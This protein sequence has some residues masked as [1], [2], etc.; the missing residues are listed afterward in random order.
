MNFG[1]IKRMLAWY[2]AFV[3]VFLLQKPLFLAVHTPAGLAVGV[4]DYLAVAWHGLAMDLCMAAYLSVVPALLLIWQVWARGRGPVVAQVVYAALVSVALAAVAVLDLAL[5]GYWGFRLDTTPLFY[6]S[7]SPSS[8]LASVSGWT[9]A[10]GTLGWLLTAT[11]IFLVLRQIAKSGEPCERSAEGGKRRVRTTAVLVV[12]TVALFVPMRGGVTVSTMNLSRAYFSAVPFLNHAAINPAFSLMYSATHQSRFDTQ[13]RYMADAEARRALG[14]L[15]RPSGEAAR[16]SITTTR[17]DVWL[18]VLESFSAHLM[19]SLGGEAV[20]TRLDSVARTGVTFTNFYANSFRTDRGLVSILSGYP[21]QP[22]TSVMKYVE[23]AEHLPSIAASLKRAGYSTAYYYGGDANFTNMLAYLRSSGFDRIVSDRDFP[24]SQRLSKWGAH[25]EHVFRRAL[26]DQAAEQTAPRF[27]VIQ[28]SSS[29]EP[30]EVPATIAPFK[31]GTR[32]NAFAYADSCLGGFLDSLRRSPRWERTLVVM[33]PDHYGCYPQHLDD[34][35]A[36]HHVPLVLTGGAIKE[37]AVETVH[38]SQI[39]IAATL[40][41]LLGLPHGEFTF[42]KDLRSPQTAHYAVFT[43]KDLV[44]LAMPGR[45]AVY[46]CDAGI[47][48]KATD[49]ALVTQAKAYLQKLYDNLSD[50]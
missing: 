12:M 1:P 48:Q 43:E 21:A 36:R 30:F 11:V 3:A 29:H 19:P 9:V 33:V 46:N 16:F 24:L 7:T 34:P 18:I 14:E 32:Q 4:G 47:P 41:G 2:G 50:L 49:T 15:N 13:Y 17:P 22:S 10:A 39:D 44:A 40:L 27:T 25:D 6:F 45:K 20:A 26:T 8:A 31:A 5:Y 42:S 23:K 38:G 35:M 28:T 37:P